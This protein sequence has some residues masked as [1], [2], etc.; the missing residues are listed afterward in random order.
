VPGA[1]AG[2]RRAQ[3]VPEV[4]VRE[5]WR[6]ML[7]IHPALLPAFGGKGLYGARV[8]RAVLASGARWSG[9]SVHFVDAAYDTGPILAQAVVRVAPTDTPA[10]LAARVLAQARRPRSPCRAPAPR[11]APLGARAQPVPPALA[12]GCARRLA[13]QPRRPLPSCGG[14]PS[15]ACGSGTP[16]VAASSAGRGTARQAGAAARQLLPGLPS[17]LTERAAG[18]ERLSAPGARAVPRGRGRAGGRAAHLARGRRAH[19]VD[20][21]LSAR[22]RP[23]SMLLLA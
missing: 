8:H 2:R 1:D 17:A 10:A 9:P 5:Y 4:V 20:R 12:Q 21:A 3:L 14:R 18:P 23:H 6:A 13:L 7:N 11:P 19:H 22:A 16:C 15:W